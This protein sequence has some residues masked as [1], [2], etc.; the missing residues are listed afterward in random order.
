MLDAPSRTLLSQQAARN[1]RAHGRGNFDVERCQNQVL[2]QALNEIAMRRIWEQLLQDN[3]PEAWLLAAGIVLAVLAAVWLARGIVAGVIR[4]LARRTELKLDDALVES[5]RATRLWLFAPLALFAGASALAIPSR[6]DSLLQNVAMVA[7]VA[8]FAVWVNCWLMRY[9]ALRAEAARTVDPAATTTVN[10]LAFVGRVLVWAMALLIA[11]D[12]LGFNVT[13]LVA[14]LGIGGIAVA[15]AVQ[16]IL[17]DLF[18]SMAIVLDKP[19]QVGDFIIVGDKAGSVEKVGLKTTRVKSL[20]GEQLV[21]ANAQLLNAQIQN[22]KKM[23]ERRIAFTIG[24][25]YETPAEKLRAIPGWIKAAVEALPEVRF[26][27]A[28]FKAYADFSLEFET[29]YYVLSADYAVYMDRQQ[30]INLALFEKFAAEGVAFAYPTRT[31]YIRQ[32][33]A[34]GR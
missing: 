28:H 23:Q 33:A 3:A 11:L 8:Q 25:T 5:V 20:S 24:V 31:L 6:L 27:R 32:E 30:A 18:A 7:L 14:G 16:N 4:R 21:F 10:L 15:L 2:H 19:F 1:K 26:D 17:G 13:A 12:Q 22:Y 9:L 34:A 29:V